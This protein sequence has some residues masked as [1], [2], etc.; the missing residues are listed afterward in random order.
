MPR[1]C[2]PSLVTTISFRH[3]AADTLHEPDALMWCWCAGKT[4]SLQST[5]IGPCALQVTVAKEMATVRPRNRSHCSQI[6]PVHPSPILVTGDSVTLHTHNSTHMFNKHIHTFFYGPPFTFF[7]PFSFLPFITSF[8]GC[9][10]LLL[11]PLFQILLFP[12]LSLK[13]TS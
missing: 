2:S 1:I 11:V 3:R 12:S 10:S 8:S 6:K 4:K 5:N 9:P 13:W 7:S